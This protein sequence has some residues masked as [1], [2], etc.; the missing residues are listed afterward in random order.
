MS[1]G[2]YESIMAIWGENIRRDRENLEVARKWE[3]Y[4]KRLEK[5]VRETAARAEAQVALNNEML[6]ELKGEKPRYL[7]L[8]ENRAARIKFRDIQRRISEVKFFDANPLGL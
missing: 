3:I 4:A 2:A 5:K 8:P 6:S 7:S 1:L